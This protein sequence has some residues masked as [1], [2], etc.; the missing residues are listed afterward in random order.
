MEE[1]M[2]LPDL[3][4]MDLPYYV[5][6]YDIIYERIRSGVLKAGDILPGENV[7]AARWKVSRST[8][9]MAVR[10]LEEDGL[11]YKMQG[12][13]TTVAG[14]KDEEKGMLN[15]IFNPCLTCCVEEITRTE[16]KIFLQKG[17]QLVSHLLREEPEAVQM[18]AVDM[19]YY[20]K[21][22]HVAS[23]VSIFPMEELEERGISFED[24]EAMKQMTLEKIY[25]KAWK[26]RISLSVMEGSREEEDKPVCSSLLVI[27]EVLWGRDE[28]LSYHKYWMDSNWYRFAVERRR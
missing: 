14:Y 25:E 6:I 26:S 16:A 9:R 21:E 27:D 5:Q 22:E 10:K 8:V 2:Q 23:S 13:K 4:E 15:R 20:V 19:K 11:I 12:K 3:K 17:G 1:T 28:P 7:L 24:T 18:A